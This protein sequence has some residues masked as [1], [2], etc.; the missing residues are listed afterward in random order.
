MHFVLTKVKDLGL[1]D[2]KISVAL[3]RVEE[4][5]EDSTPSRSFAQQW[6][7]LSYQKDIVYSQKYFNTFAGSHKADVGGEIRKASDF[8]VI[9]RTQQF[10]RPGPCA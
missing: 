2:S 8:K 9:T 3:I 5:Q 10:T 6:L 1:R 7:S 4:Q